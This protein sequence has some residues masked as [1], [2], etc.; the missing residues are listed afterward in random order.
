[1]K[2]KPSKIIIA[3]SGGG[4]LIATLLI[5][6]G[7]VIESP[8]LKRAGA[9][10]FLVVAAITSLPFILLGCYILWQTMF[11]QKKNAK[12]SQEKEK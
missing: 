3:V 12:D 11:G 4:M 10:F 8:A 5:I 6:F 2:I 7:V 1:M 9:I